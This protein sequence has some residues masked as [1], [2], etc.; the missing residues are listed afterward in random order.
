MKDRKLNEYDFKYRIDL[1]FDRLEVLQKYIN[2]LNNIDEMDL[3]LFNEIKQMINNPKKIRRSVKKLVA[4]DKATEA[5]T[6]KAKSKIFN[7]INLLR[8][9]GKKI[10]PYSI[11]KISGVAYQ[12]VRK[13]I[14]C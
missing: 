8:L 10:T 2:K 6:A 3:I 12:T 13:Y 9:Q 5:R 4:A 11:A 7:A 14:K 1:D